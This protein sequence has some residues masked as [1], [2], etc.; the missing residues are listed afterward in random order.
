MTNILTKLYIALD[1]SAGIVQTMQKFLNR[2]HEDKVAID[3]LHIT[4]NQGQILGIASVDEV[5]KNT[6]VKILGKLIQPV[7]GY[8]K[9][10]I[11]EDETTEDALI[12]YKQKY[13]VEELEHIVERICREKKTIL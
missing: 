6:L 10:L 11:E 13:E 1:K 3:E 4:I 2:H 8:L 5:G 9:Y 12:N 7:S